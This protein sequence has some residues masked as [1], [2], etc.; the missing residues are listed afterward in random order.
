MGS[1]A[2]KSR[3]RSGIEGAAMERRDALFKSCFKKMLFYSKMVKQLTCIRLNELKVQMIHMEEPD[4]E[5]NG[6]RK[7]FRC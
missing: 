7:W 4:R 6:P 5:A 3:M 1:G 2:R